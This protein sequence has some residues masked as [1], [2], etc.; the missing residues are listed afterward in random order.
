MRT[1]VYVFAFL[2]TPGIA[3]GHD[4]YT[5]L[6]KG[7]PCQCNDMERRCMPVEATSDGKGNYY[8]PSS[9][10][11]IPSERALPSPDERFHRCTGPLNMMWRSRGGGQ[12]PEGWI[13]VPNNHSKDGMPRTECFWAPRLIF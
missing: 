2:F 8:L 9:D 5:E 13:E 6:T 10:E 3:Y 11:I 7:T 12:G 4:I 1:A